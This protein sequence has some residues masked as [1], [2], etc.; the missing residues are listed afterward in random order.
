MIKRKVNMEEKNNEVILEPDDVLVPVDGLAW[1]KPRKD[2]EKDKKKKGKEVILE[3]D[4][5]FV[6]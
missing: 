6:G 5:S 1:G 4:N 2:K 3:P